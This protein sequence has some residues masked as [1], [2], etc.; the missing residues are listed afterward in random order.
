MGLG[1]LFRDSSVSVEPEK[2]KTGVTMTLNDRDLDLDP[3][4]DLNI[5][6]TE[7]D[8]DGGTETVPQGAVRA[9][10]G[11][12]VKLTFCGPG[13]RTRSQWPPRG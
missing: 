11:S 7:E 5:D 4:R 9:V 6:M 10:W 3:Q 1:L 12:Q 8:M 13:H 2:E